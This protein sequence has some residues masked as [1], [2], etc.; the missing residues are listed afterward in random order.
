M[1]S[2]AGGSVFD[3]RCAASS[4]R[5]RS[6]DG[7]RGDHACDRRDN[8]KGYAARVA[9][10]RGR[11]KGQTSRSSSKRPGLGRLAKADRRVARVR[12]RRRRAAAH[13]KTGQLE[14]RDHRRGVFD[15]RIADAR[16]GH[17]LAACGSEDVEHDALLLLADLHAER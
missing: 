13:G 3:R 14:L 12:S 17:R 1:R 6:D 16:I 7:E 15:T 4:R 10:A 9:A 8:R 2:G 11:V 5:K